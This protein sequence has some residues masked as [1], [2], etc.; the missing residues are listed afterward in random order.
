[1]KVENVNIEKNKSWS[2]EV[3]GNTI[4][5]ENSGAERL[6]VNDKMQDISGGVSFNSHLTGKLPDGKEIK[7]VLI[8]SF[9]KV[10]CYI[11]VNHELVLED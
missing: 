1:M 9:S 11:F 5:L 7:A 8:S 4:R 3:D 10:H 2:V 6:Y